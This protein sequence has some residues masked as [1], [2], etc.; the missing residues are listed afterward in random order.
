VSLPA[1][2]ETADVFGVPV[3]V[4]DYRFISSEKAVKGLSTESMRVAA[5]LAQDEQVIHVDDPD[6][7]TLV[8][9]NGCSRKYFESH[10]DAASD[11][12]NVRVQTLVRR[13]AISHRGTCNAVLLGLR[14]GVSVILTGET[15]VLASSTDSHVRVGFLELT[16][17]LIS[18]SRS[19]DGRRSLSP[20]ASGDLLFF[21]R[22]Q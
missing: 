17:R 7:D 16:T 15:W 14:E 10:F 2:Q 3:K 9:Q 11:E 6:A 20:S 8:A 19:A 1:E 18:E 13:E 4:D 5:A 21:E 12:H 22:R